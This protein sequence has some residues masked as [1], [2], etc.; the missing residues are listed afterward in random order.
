MILYLKKKSLAKA[1]LATSFL[2]V[3]DESATT[4]IG[5]KREKIELRYFNYQK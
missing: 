2:E 3:R 5:E 1:M 4:Q